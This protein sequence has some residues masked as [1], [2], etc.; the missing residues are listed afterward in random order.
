MC[1]VIAAPPTFLD[2]QVEPAYPPADEAF[3]RTGIFEWKISG[4]GSGFGGAGRA[5]WAAER[6]LA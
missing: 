1:S 3:I 6:R 5:R 2:E 4:N